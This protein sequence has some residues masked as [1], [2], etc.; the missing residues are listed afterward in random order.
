MLNSYCIFYTISRL[1]AYDLLTFEDGTTSSMTPPAITC[2]RCLANVERSAGL[3]FCP[4]C[5]AELSG[6]D[7]ARAE[8]VT[9]RAGE[10]ELV[11]GERLAF[12]IVANL[13]RCS[14]RKHGQGVFKV[15]RTAQSNRHLAHDS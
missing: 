15:A 4:H 7:A 14:I 6:A 2:P 13:Y 5:G 10:L 12:G 11:V 3:K 9:L 1:I 8:P